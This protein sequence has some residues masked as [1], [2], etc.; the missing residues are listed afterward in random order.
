MSKNNWIV[1][2]I[3]ALLIAIGSWAIFSLARIGMVNLLAKIGI[4]S[5]WQSLA[6]IIILVIMVLLILGYSFRKALKKLVR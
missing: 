6:L 3:V 4:V 1:G 5:E 2:I